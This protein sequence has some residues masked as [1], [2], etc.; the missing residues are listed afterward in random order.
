MLYSELRKQNR[1]DLAEHVPLPH[2]LS[3]YIDPCNKCNYKCDYCFH[4]VD[5][6]KVLCGGYF[7]LSLSDAKKIADQVQELG[8]ITTINFHVTGE[9]LLNKELPAI[10]NTFYERRLAERIQL[11]TNAS[12]LTKEKALALL[13]SGVGFFRIS[14]YGGTSELHQQ[15]SHSAVT[16]EMIRE[17]VSQ[18]V[19]LRNSGRFSASIAVKMLATGDRNEELSFLDFFNGVADECF[20]ES[21]HNFSSSEYFDVESSVHVKPERGKCQICPLPFYRMTIH[22]NLDV[23]C[24]D[25]DAFHKVVLGNL[26]KTSLKDIWNGEI[27]HKL[28]LAHLSK[29]F[30]EGHHCSTCE[31]YTTQVDDLSQLSAAEYSNRLSNKR[32]VF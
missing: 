23:T 1:I 21:V 16:L 10:I 14:L 8:K 17:N 13:Q 31:F 26:R 6:Y 3:L 4:S 12:L 28:Q 20:I 11:T 24:C 9:P 15:R 29:N 25:A 19:V 32:G 22:S 5:N 18:L 27:L 30:P 2:P 7:T